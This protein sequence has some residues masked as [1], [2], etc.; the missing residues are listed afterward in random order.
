[1]REGVVAEPAGQREAAKAQDRADHLGRLGG[2]PVLALSQAQPSPTP[3][4]ACSRRQAPT[5]DSEAKRAVPAARNGME[6]RGKRRRQMPHR[7]QDERDGKSQ[8]A[9]RLVP[10]APVRPRAPLA[11]AAVAP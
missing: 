10:P 7:H 5:S 2:R 4:S 3:E 9:R 8:N 1:M 11:H 6:T